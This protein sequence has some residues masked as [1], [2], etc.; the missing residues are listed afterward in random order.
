MT[1]QDLVANFGGVGDGQ[2]VTLTASITNDGSSRPRVLTVSGGTPFVSG[3]A[4]KGIYLVVTSIDLGSGVH[5]TFSGTIATFN[6]STSINLNGN[7]PSTY[8][9]QTID[10]LWGTD[11]INALVGAS[12]SYRAWAQ[13]LGATL[14]DMTAPAGYYCISDALPFALNKGV[15]NSLIRGPLN[16]AASCKFAPLFPAEMRFGSDVPINNRGLTDPGG[17]SARIQTA[18]K[19]TSTVTLVD[20]VTYGARVTVGLSCIITCDDLQS[21]LNGGF[22]YPPNPYL[23]EHNVITGYSGGVITLQNPLKNTYKS[24]YPQ[25]DIGGGFSADQGGPATIYIIADFPQSVELRDLTIESPYNQSAC[26]ARDVVLTRVVNNGPGLYPTQ[27]KTFLADTCTYPQA[28]EID[29]INGSITFQNCAM[30]TIGFQSASPDLCTINGGTCDGIFGS[31]KV[32][33]LS[34]I[35]FSGGSAFKFGA[36]GFGTT[37]RITM[38]NCSGIDS[39]LKGGGSTDDL[40]MNASAFYS[41]SGG[42]ISFPKSANDGS[43]QNPSR[44][45]NVGSWIT[46]DD[47][48]IDQVVDVYEDGTNCYIQLAKSA[49]TWPF[50]PVIRINAHECPDFT[51]RGCTGAAPE[52]EDWNQA[53]A[54]I[55]IWSYSKRTY[56]AGASAATA[57]VS[58]ALV[59]GTFKTMKLTVGPTYSGTS[60]IFFES[61]FDN[62]FVYKSDYSTTTIAAE[63]NMKTSGLRTINGA[64]TSSGGVAGDTLTDLTSAG[65][66]WMAGASASFPVFSANVTNGD[67]PTVTVEITADQGIPPASAAQLRVGR[68]S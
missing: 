23:F 31:P 2:R 52:L 40:H 59:I 39:F 49:G 18:A 65:A 63:V 45:F 54:R 3:D 58:Q 17:N 8:T 50:T 33:V 7:A 66:T 9:N 62:W 15:Q 26:H 38:T 44:L 1:T 28:I 42:V 20:A 56:V 14:A 12:G 22:G 36:L 34:G 51:M 16:N 24:T 68:R 48:F 46:F 4:T 67:T 25:W 43:L 21:G 11:N 32:L 60:L 35:A 6:N 55:P 19:G 29:K 61:Q 53:P 10:I 27:N 30:H 41:M 64:G 13:T 57:N 5:P 37:S 47:K